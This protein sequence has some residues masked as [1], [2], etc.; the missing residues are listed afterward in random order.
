MDHYVIASGALTAVG[1]QDEIITVI[2]IDYASAVGPG[3]LPT[4]GLM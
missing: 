4:Q 3:F 2:V 1:S